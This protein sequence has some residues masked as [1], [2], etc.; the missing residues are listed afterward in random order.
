MTEEAKGTPD[1]GVEEGREGGRARSRAPS[2]AR[3]ATRSSN[4]AIVPESDRRRT[5]R[6]RH[7]SWARAMAVATRRRAWCMAELY[8]GAREAWR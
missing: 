3:W 6:S 7:W 4:L 1:E 8:R 2:A 5:P